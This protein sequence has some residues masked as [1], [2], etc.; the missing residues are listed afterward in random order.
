MPLVHE[1]PPL[2]GALHHL[3]ATVYSVTPS[4]VAAYMCA[5]A[6]FS[7]TGFLWQPSP[8]GVDEPVILIAIGLTMGVLLS[9]AFVA[10][11]RYISRRRQQTAALNALAQRLQNVEKR[12]Q[13]LPVRGRRP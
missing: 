2:R 1:L 7:I 8:P 3:K 5:H 13:G 6:V 10:T 12:L 9:I 4:H 11:R